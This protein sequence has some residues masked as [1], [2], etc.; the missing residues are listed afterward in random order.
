MSKAREAPLRAAGALGRH[1]HR[2]GAAQ[3]GPAADAR[4]WPIEKVEG[5]Y[6]KP[7]ENSANL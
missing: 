1:G 7:I 4:R 3:W 6:R 5:C 2:P